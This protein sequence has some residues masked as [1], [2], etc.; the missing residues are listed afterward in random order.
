LFS[1]KKLLLVAALF[2]A[3]FAIANLI[4]FELHQLG[5][6][7]HYIPSWPMNVFGPSEATRHYRLLVSLLVLAAFFIAQRLLAKCDYRLPFVIVT[8]FAL[9]I[10]SNLI[11]GLEEGLADPVAA[12]EFNDEAT[13]Q[14]YHDAVKITDPGAF[15]R[16]YTALQPTLYMHARTH[17]PGPVLLMYALN[18]GL[19][20][21]ALISLVIAAVAVTTAGC[22][23]YKLLVAEV[24]PRLAGFMT[25]LFLL[26]PSVQIYYL[27]TV[28]ALVAALLLGVFYCFKR[29]T[30][31]HLC[32]AATLLTI[33]F[34]LTFL[35][36]WIVPVL[37]GYE[38]IKRRNIM[39][40][41]AVVL[42]VMA[43][44]VALYFASGFNLLASFRTASAI[45]NEHGFM[46]LHN[47]L[48]Y[49]VSRAQ[50]IGELIL[51]F[52]PYL[53]LLF[54]RSVRGSQRDLGTWLA[55]GS[56]ALL[57]AA[58]TFRVGETARVCNFLYPFLLLPV[59]RYLNQRDAGNSE[60]TQ[61]VWLVFGQTILMQ[62]AGSYF[63]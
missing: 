21:P 32:A 16:N 35:A 2:C 52:G 60:K 46:L 61:L 13:P 51:F 49:F 56:F 45:E 19:R 28:D 44:Y 12:D 53:G 54:V 41:S 31:L 14:Y 43:V 58:G 57:L 37:C 22:F 4:V 29:A 17:P 11:Q 48:D 3:A 27:A 59:A 34:M 40:G 8:G 47:P 7:V 23:F 36:V 20:E 1:A 62:A 50:S 9:I 18:K 38:L 6:H 42:A 63:W 26:L 33:S 5:L 15:F 24:Q 10:G 39:R 25:F 55:L 30:A